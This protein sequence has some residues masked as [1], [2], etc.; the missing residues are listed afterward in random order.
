MDEGPRFFTV[1]EAN[2]L[3]SALELQFGR[4]AQARS[5]LGPV[6]QALGGPDEAVAL[7]HDGAPTPAGRE[8]EAGKLRH[9]AGEITGAVERINELGCLVKDVE[10]GLVDFYAMVDGEPAFLCWQFGERAVSHWHGID[11]GYAGRKPIEGVAVPPPA[12]PN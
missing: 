5:E 7:L 11:E 8:A 10:I 9:L 12:F 3:V 6:I 2:A 4:I 1:E